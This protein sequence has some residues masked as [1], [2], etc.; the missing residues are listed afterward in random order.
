MKTLIRITEQD[1]HRMIKESVNRILSERI[2]GE[3][4]MSD[5]EVMWRRN[6]NFE[7]DCDYVPNKLHD[8]PFAPKYSDRIEMEAPYHTPEEMEHRVASDR[9]KRHNAT[10]R[11]H[12]PSLKQSMFK[13]DISV[14]GDDI[15][16]T[17]D[18]AMYGDGAI[19]RSYIWDSGDGYYDYEIIIGDASFRGHY[20]SDGVHC[21][22]VVIGNGGYGHQMNPSDIH[23]AKFEQWFEERLAPRF[24]YVLDRKINM[25]DFE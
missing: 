1:L 22:E 14:G 23:T 19:S 20:A 2:K 24:Q 9:L 13:E 21:D 8:D 4:G 17:S 10:Q 25:G 11:V 18:V 5:D 12:K 6:R 15:D 3:K 7:K 16:P